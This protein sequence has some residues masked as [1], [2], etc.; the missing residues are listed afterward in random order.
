MDSV[1]MKQPFR[2]YQTVTLEFAES[3]VR[4]FLTVKK[5]TNSG[6]PDCPALNF[7]HLAISPSLTLGS[8][9]ITVLLSPF[10]TVGLRVSILKRWK[11]TLLPFLFLSVHCKAPGRGS[12]GQCVCGFTS[13]PVKKCRVEWGAAPRSRES[14]EGCIHVGA[15]V[16][17][18][19]GT[20]AGK[21]WHGEGG[22][23]EGR[24]FLRSARTE[25]G[26]TDEE[27]QHGGGAGLLNDR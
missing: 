14:R 11:A 19:E 26:W 12:A 1:Q 7:I 17:R 25:G 9:N 16:G 13:L 6:K 5:N 23:L 15:Q 18:K 24:L 27:G 3:Q 8:F 4:Q 22:F 2:V 20:P 10:V 21:G